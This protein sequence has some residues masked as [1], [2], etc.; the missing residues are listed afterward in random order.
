MHYHYQSHNLSLC[1]KTWV[2]YISFYYEKP[3]RVKSVL[4]ARKSFYP[5]S[6]DYLSPNENIAFMAESY[7]SGGE[8]TTKETLSM[9][10]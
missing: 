9:V 2:W 8:M 7:P 3:R 1:M 10:G 5:L 4:L 6:R